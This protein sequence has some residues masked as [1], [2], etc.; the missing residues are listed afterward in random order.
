[1]SDAGG[2]LTLRIFVL[3]IALPYLVG[4]Y[5]SKHNLEFTR[6]QLHAVTEYLESFY[7]EPVKYSEASPDTCLNRLLV[8]MHNG[9]HIKRHDKPMEN[10]TIV[11]HRN[12][13][14]APCAKTAVDIIQGL[15]RLLRTQGRCPLNFEKYQLDALLTRLFHAILDDQTACHPVHPDAE[16]PD[17][18]TGGLHAYCDRGP[19]RTPILTDHDD[20]VPIPQNE[21]ETT[22]SLPCHFHEQHGMRITS[23]PFLAQI[24]RRATGPPQQEVC[25]DNDNAM[26]CA[27]STDTNTREL[28]LYAIPAG[29]VFVF[30]ARH[31]GQ[32][33]SL[34]HVSGA[35]PQLPV[36]LQVLS[37]RPRIYELFNFF[38]RRDSDDLVQ[39]AMEET[40]EAY[41]IKRSTVGSVGQSQHGRRTSESGFDTHGPVASK[42]KRRGMTA[43]GFDQYY[44]SH[45]DGLQILRYNETTAY[46]S[47]M[48]WMEPSP[49]SEDDFESSGTG[50]N[51]FATILLYLSDMGEDEGGE[52]V[53]PQAE[54]ER[55]TSETESEVRR[56]ICFG[57]GIPRKRLMLVLFLSV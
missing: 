8:T 6:K 42:L 46:N 36:Y 4:F 21:D 53:F 51:R 17:A 54:F 25:I 50:G 9:R 15:E 2:P 45:T 47:H 5:Y 29:R 14:A 11:M 12:G 26:E 16:N 52:T 31:V 39:A 28:H 10:L 49:L 48:D 27:A 37:L 34:P 32:I 7:P 44:E 13:E 19:D 38:D 18:E 22:T 24:A 35:D 43:L 57:D 1:M 3:W 56:E 40:R 23:L 41:R 30:E 33:I 20:L 55:Q